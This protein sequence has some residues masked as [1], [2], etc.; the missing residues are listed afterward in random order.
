VF[1]LWRRKYRKQ[2]NIS[3]PGDIIRATEARIID[4]WDIQ[5][6]YKI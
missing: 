3:L 1:R 2:E 4:V 6:N 5:H